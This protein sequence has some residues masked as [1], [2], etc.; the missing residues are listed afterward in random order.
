[1]H[2]L[3][4]QYKLMENFQALWFVEINR[5]WALVSIRE[6]IRRFWGKMGCGLYGAFP[7]LTAGGLQ[8]P[9]GLVRKS[10]E[11]AEK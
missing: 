1:M 3:S 4:P 11:S 10:E 5:D 6:K 2:L 8:D 7:A 9:I